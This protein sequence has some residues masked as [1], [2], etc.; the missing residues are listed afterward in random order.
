MVRIR[1][2]YW[3]F[4]RRMFGP[5]ASTV[6]NRLHR[7]MPHR[8]SK[9]LEHVRE[10]SGSANVSIVLIDRHF[11][12]D[13]GRILSLCIDCLLSTLLTVIDCA[14]SVVTS[15]LHIRALLMAR[16]DSIMERGKKPRR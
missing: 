7:V 9:R 6:D 3:V 12:E 2:C 10:Q 11:C 5:D 4:H 8:R 13:V 16:S 15:H 1:F 14:E